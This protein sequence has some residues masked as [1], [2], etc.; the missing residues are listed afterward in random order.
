MD[1]NNN[2]N[3]INCVDNGEGMA[4]PIPQAEPVEGAPVEEPVAEPIAE[5]APT[6]APYNGATGGGR[7][8]YF[9]DG[10]RRF[11]PDNAG[12]TEPPKKKKSKG[13]LI[14]GIIVVSI[15]FVALIGVFSI[16]GIKQI[17]DKA[18]PNGYKDNS[19]SLSRPD[20]N[21]SMVIDN[22]GEDYIPE[23]VSVPEIVEIAPVPEESFDSLV[24]LYNDCAKSCVTILCEVEVNNGFYT[25]TGQSLGSGFIIEGSKD[26]KK[27]IYIVTNHHVI[28][29]AKKI[30]V[31]YNDDKIFEAKLLGSDELSDIAVLQTTRTDVTPIAMGDS[32]KIA[33]GQWVVAIGTPSAEELKN[34]MSY[35]IIS[36]LNRKIPVANDS[37]TVVKTMKV[38]QTTATLNPGNSGGPLINMAGQVIGI[39]AM[40]LMQDYEGI[41]FALPSTEA[42]FIINSLIEYGKVVDNSG[43]FVSGTAQL[44]ITGATVTDEVRESYSLGEDCPDGVL[45]V[46][47]NRGTS[48]YEAGLSIFDIITEFNGT[49]VESIEQLKELI[50][51]CNAGDKVT[52]KYYRI[53]RL[54]EDSGYRTISFKLDNAK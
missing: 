37:G 21:T 50:G 6:Q 41:G 54:G 15:L 23:D 53:G 32:S 40:K 42:S 12:Y 18:F 19:P 13:G 22:E 49:K 1:E 24:A 34:T 4:E 2:L 26:G 51:E 7:F 33:V 14:A 11:V 35:G 29:G 47:V 3:N 27:G 5:P 45:V 30:S 17:V 31:K 16:F 39:N 38:I 10:T 48:V 46:N 52:L 28:D 9:A 8:V 44:G 25:Q 43:G 36:G 20:D